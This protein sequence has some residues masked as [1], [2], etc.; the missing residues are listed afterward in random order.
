MVLENMLEFFLLH[1]IEYK[2]IKGKR[3]LIPEVFLSTI[4]F[5]FLSEETRLK[6]FFSVF[7][8]V[9][10]WKLLSTHIICVAQT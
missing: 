4:S 5:R 3:F 9:D 10:V 7:L 2:K 1:G 6:N 8:F